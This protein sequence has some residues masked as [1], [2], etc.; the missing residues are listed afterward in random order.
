MC[1]DMFMQ[2]CRRC[3]KVY[4]NGCSSHRALLDPSEVVTDPGAPEER[5]TTPT[6]QRVCQSCYDEVC[7]DVPGPLRSSQGTGIEGVMVNNQSLLVGGHMRAGE[8]TSQ[9]SD[10]TEFVFFLAV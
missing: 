10:L 1:T 2:H 6:L 4:C 3:G 8:D 7:T 5:H 9:I